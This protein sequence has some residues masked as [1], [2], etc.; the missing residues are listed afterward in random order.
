MR[1][2]FSFGKGSLGGGE[3]PVLYAFLELVDLICTIPP[4]VG[5][6]NVI[7]DSCST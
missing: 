7:S 2:C 3:K 1:A 6:S 4:L 5:Q